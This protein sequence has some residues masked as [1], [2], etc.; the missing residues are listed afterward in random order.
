MKPQWLKFDCI[1]ISS[2]IHIPARLKPGGE[3]LSQRQYFFVQEIRKPDEK[4]TTTD[5]K[6][7]LAFLLCLLLLCPQAVA[8]SL[9]AGSDCGEDACPVPLIQGNQQPVYAIVPRRGTTRW[10]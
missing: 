8:A 9:A 5:M 3:S 4:G 1:P 6:S 10:T 2:R 7:C